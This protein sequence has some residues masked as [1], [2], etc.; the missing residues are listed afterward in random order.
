MPRREK[1]DTLAAPGLWLTLSGLRD[2][3]T[4][5]VEWG[6]LS[7]RAAHHGWSPFFEGGAP[8]IILDHAELGTYS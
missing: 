7:P 3:A 5:L 2:L 4:D 8:P 6:V 1:G